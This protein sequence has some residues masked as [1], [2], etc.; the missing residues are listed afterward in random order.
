MT[1]IA[2]F[3]TKIDV[4]DRLSV[5]PRLTYKVEDTHWGYIVSATYGPGFG[6]IAAQAID[7]PRSR[8][9]ERPVKRIITLSRD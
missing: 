3:E 4:S 2:N 6:I 1:D 7:V 8:I 5:K 9:V